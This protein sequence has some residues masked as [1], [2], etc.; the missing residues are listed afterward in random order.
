MD[1]STEENR[2]GAETSRAR[3]RREV[4]A[5]AGRDEIP[6]SVQ[7]RISAIIERDDQAAV[8]KDWL[9]AQLSSLA[10]RKD[11]ISEVELTKQSSDF[12]AVFTAAC[13]IGSLTDINAPNWQPVLKFLGTV[14]RSRAIGGFSASET[15]TFVFSLKQPL[16]MRLRREFSKDP[17]VLADELW[18]TTVLLDKLGLYTTEV[19]QKSREYNQSAYYLLSPCMQ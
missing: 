16:F 2:K 13:R 19:F 11:L 6:T 10:A 1:H 18:N 8:L 14:S 9:P 7:T 5:A 17:E 4:A 3:G 12:L 15:A